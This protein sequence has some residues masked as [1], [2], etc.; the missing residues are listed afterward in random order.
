MDDPRCTMGRDNCGSK[1]RNEDERTHKICMDEGSKPEVKKC[2]QIHFRDTTNDICTASN[3]MK[4]YGKKTKSKKEWKQEGEADPRC[5]VLRDTC[6]RK[7]RTKMKA[8]TKA[9]W[10][11]EAKNANKFVFETLQ[12]TCT[13][14]QSHETV[15]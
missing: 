9:V 7:Q 3:L 11:K 5:T 8:L 14:K 12:M 1:Q 10:P 13:H 15:G 6:G 4:P 2:R